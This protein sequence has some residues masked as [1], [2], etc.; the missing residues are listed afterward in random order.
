MFMVPEKWERR[1]LLLH[2]NIYVSVSLTRGKVVNFMSTVVAISQLS[3]GLLVKESLA[4][5][6]R[7][8]K[9]TEHKRRRSVTLNESLLHQIRQLP[10][11]R[12]WG[13]TF[14]VGVLQKLRHFLRCCFLHADLM[15]RECLQHIFTVVF[16]IPF[17][18]AIKPNIII[19][20]YLSI[21]SHHLL[22]FPWPNCPIFFL[23]VA[24]HYSPRSGKVTG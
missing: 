11:R 14:T 23:K 12:K 21:L 10:R 24:H 22:L 18:L 2:R 16:I 8:R 1:S 15:W 7:L 4:V 9:L 19:L 20:D 17:S 5:V 13:E 3:K 6:L